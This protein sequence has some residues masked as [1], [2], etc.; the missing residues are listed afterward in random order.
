MASKLGPT[1]CR[2]PGLTNGARDGAA[3]SAT[4]IGLQARGDILLALDTDMTVADVSVTHL[5]GESVRAAAAAT[6]VA[7]VKGREGEKRR[8]YGRLEPNG[9]PFYPFAVESY[10]RL[11]KDAID[12][13]GRLARPWQGGQG[14]RARG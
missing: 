9:Y 13:S 11:S 6:K 8:L 1:L 2:L 14:G 12:M 5:G 4:A 10:G 3:W 7:A